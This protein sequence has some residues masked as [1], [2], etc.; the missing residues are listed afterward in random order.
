L[1]RISGLRDSRSSGRRP[2]D[3]TPT[4]STGGSQHLGVPAYFLPGSIWDMASRPGAGVRFLVVNPASGPGEVLHAGYAAAVAGAQAAGIGVLG[5]VDTAH[6][7]R[8]TALVTDEID[9]YRCWYGVDGVFLD[10]SAA[11]AEALGYYEHLAAHIRSGTGSVVV[12]NPG[13]YPWQP[14]ADLADALVTFE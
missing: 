4:M 1:F 2:G 5:Y 7:R 11:T 13:V 10:Q 3:G 9:R 6:G 12:L 14:Y 8:D